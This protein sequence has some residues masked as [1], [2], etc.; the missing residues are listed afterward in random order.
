[1]RYG[2]MRTPWTPV[3]EA[4]EKASERRKIEA[5]GKIAQKLGISLEEVVAR[6]NEIVNRPYEEYAQKLGVT[7]EEFL[8]WCGL[9]TAHNRLRDFNVIDGAE[10]KQEEVQKAYLELQRIHSNIRDLPLSDEEAAQKL[11]IPVEEVEYFCLEVDKKNSGERFHKHMRELDAYLEDLKRRGLKLCGECSLNLSETFKSFSD[12]KVRFR[13]RITGS[14]DSLSEREKDL[15]RRQNLEKIVVPSQEKLGELLEI[16]RSTLLVQLSNKRKSR[17]RPKLLAARIAPDL[18][19]RL[20]LRLKDLEN[21][22]LILCEDCCLG[23]AVQMWFKENH[24][25]ALLIKLFAPR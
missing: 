11:G 24:V 18:Y 23:V 12:G 20:C 25:P 14:L 22:G 9:M 15:Y 6:R 4:R 2:I 17:L 5:N 7:V 1:M 19:E 21:E 16:I 8:D 10:F 13:K 3:L